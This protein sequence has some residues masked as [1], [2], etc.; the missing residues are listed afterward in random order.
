MQR[1]DFA[2]L[3]QSLGSQKTLTSLHFGTP[4]ARPKAYIQASL[5]AE[6]LPGMLAAHHL[7]TLLERAQQEGQI[8]GEIILVPVANPIGLAQRLDHKPMGRFELGT[9]ENFNRNYPDLCPV[10]L[11]VIRDKLGQDPL[12]N[13]QIIRETV[14]SYVEQWVPATELQ[15]LRKRLVS[16]SFDADIVLDLHC[17]CEAALHLYTETPCWPQLEPLARLLGAK[18]VLLAKN[19]GGLSF[20][21]CLSGLW[22]QLAEKVAQLGQDRPIPQACATTTIE[23]RGE[24]DVSHEWGHAD[25]QAIFG[26]LQHAGLIAGTAPALPS[27]RCEATPLAGSQTVKSP[28]PGMVVF[29]AKPGDRLNVGDL[30]AEVIDPIANTTY[31]ARAEVAGVMYARL[32]DRYVVANDDLANIAGSKPFRTGYLLGA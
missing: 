1:I 28:V 26:Y 11:P 17:D 25:A 20:D 9:S 3:S 4:G 23:L 6:E 27:S 12:E 10:V 2:L 21:E 13:V 29:A 22:W 19:S 30:V 16:L 7:R 24:A 15:S 5:H 8:Q 31:S 32:R 18:A 14:R